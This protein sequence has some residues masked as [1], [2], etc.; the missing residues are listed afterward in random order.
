MSTPYM[1]GFLSYI[2]YIISARYKL[3]TV[4]KTLNIIYQRQE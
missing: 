3:G 4:Y 1:N 2:T